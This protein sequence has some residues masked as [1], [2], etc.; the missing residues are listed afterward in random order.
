MLPSYVDE[1]RLLPWEFG[2]ACADLPWYMTSLVC[3]VM[4]MSSDNRLTAPYCF[5]YNSSRNRF[6][7]C[8]APFQPLLP[9]CPGNLEGRN[10]QVH[11]PSLLS[12]TLFLTSACRSLLCGL[13]VFRYSEVHGK[14]RC[15]GAGLA[16]KWY[17]IETAWSCWWC[18]IVHMKLRIS[19]AMKVIMEAA[20]LGRRQQYANVP[21]L[22]SS[23]LRYQVE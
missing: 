9:I 11:Y 4:K 13:A 1:S 21:L 22:S 10:L 14:I 16:R 6:S 19:F 17:L 8:P 5:A 12:P 15:W 3:F 2:S 23:Q 20:R 18:D 7:F